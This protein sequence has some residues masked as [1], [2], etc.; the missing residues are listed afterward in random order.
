MK[1]MTPKHITIKFLKS[2]L[3]KKKSEE[4]QGKK[5]THYRQSVK[6]EY[7]F[8]NSSGK[9]ELWTQQ[10]NIIKYWMKK[11]PIFNLEFYNQKKY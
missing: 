9:V 11:K 3:K 10:I 8:D 2:V 4:Q 5:K 7:N 1:K 6:D